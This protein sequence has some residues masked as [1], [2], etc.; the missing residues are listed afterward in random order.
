MEDIIKICVLVGYEI[1][2][3]L[4]SRLRNSNEKSAQS[5]KKF[6]TVNCGNVDVDPDPVGSASFMR[7]RIHFNY[8]VCKAK[9]YFFTSNIVQNIENSDIHDA[10]EED[11]TM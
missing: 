8:A 4:M 6:S 9:L 10:E 5:I 7:N 11:N 1:Y 2:C 3:K